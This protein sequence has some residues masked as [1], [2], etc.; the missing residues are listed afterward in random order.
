M[1]NYYH[2]SHACFAT[3]NLPKSWEIFCCLMCL[4]ISCERTATC[5]VVAKLHLLW[6]PFPSGF[7]VVRKA[8]T[9][10][11]APHLLFFT[12]EE[13]V[14]PLPHHIPLPFSG[15]IWKSICMEIILL[16]NIMHN[17]TAAIDCCS[18]V[19]GPGMK[20]PGNTP[21]ADWALYWLL[22]AALC[23]VIHDGCWLVG[24]LPPWAVSGFGTTLLQIEL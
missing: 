18:S 9:R 22:M 5:G 19:L 12:A 15:M 24:H 17:K 11:V 23:T 1:V 4:R 7:T 21:R 14:H 2:M 8:L 16:Q 13:F 10:K 20:C 6:D 3:I